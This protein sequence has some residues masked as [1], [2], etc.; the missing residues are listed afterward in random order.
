MNKLYCYTDSSK[1]PYSNECGIAFIVVNKKKEIIHEYSKK[2]FN[3]TNNRGEL[4]AIRDAIK[5]V[6]HY[7]PEIDKLVV[8]S[9]SSWAVRG[10]L[11]QFNVK[12]HLDLFKEIEFLTEKANFKVSVC[13]IKAHNGNKFNEYV[14]R[15]ANEIRLRKT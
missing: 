2:C 15:L 11:K 4:M 1:S 3:I 14:D 8:Y 13:W 10:I 5:Y 12:K 9:D 6:L 7:Y